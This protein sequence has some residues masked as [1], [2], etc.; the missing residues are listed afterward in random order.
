MTVWQ[1]LTFAHYQPQQW[2]RGSLLHRLFGSLQSWRASSQLLGWSEAIGGLLLALVYGAAPVVPSTA[3]GLGLAAIAAYWVLL[4]LTDSDLQ[5]A[6]PIHWLV[7]L[8]WGVAAVATVLSPVRSAA[9]VG[10]ARLTL[11]LLTFAL[12]ARILRNPRLRSLVLSVI[13][14]TSLFVSAYGLN[15][16]IYGVE[17]LATWVDPNSVAEFTSRVY[18][19]LGNP[20]L[21][22]AYL[23][24]TTAFS[25][26]AIGAWRGWLPKLLAIAA[27]GASSLCLILTYSRGGWLGFVAMIFVWTM[28][29]LYWFQPRLPAPWRRWLFPVVLG[30]L[31]AILLIAVVG[32]EPLRVRALSIFV[33]REDSSNNFRINVW[34]AVLQMIQDR[35]WLGIGPGNTAFNQ[36]YPLYQQARFTAL[37]AYSVPLEVMVEAGVIGLASFIWLLLVTTVTAV[38]QLTRLRRDRD[39]QSFWLIASLAGLAGMLGH[40]LFDTVLYRPEVSTLWWLCIGSIASFWQ[41]QATVLPADS[42]EKM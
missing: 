26:A 36:V 31:V 12:A 27:T 13:V 16:W 22:A 17:A 19:Y 35:P 24:P 39:P 6:T 33:G 3:I 25:A 4:S 1:A 38:R 32:L 10:L 9:I 5:Q 42:D 40:G 7:L 28:L 20:N 34:L 37:S 14:V 11:Y 8:Y 30:G 15:Q 21:L 23:V 18:S 41:P 29:G 2:G